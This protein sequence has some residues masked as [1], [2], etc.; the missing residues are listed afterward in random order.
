MGSNSSFS[1]VLLVGFLALAGMMLAGCASSHPTAPP[2]QPTAAVPLPDDE[3]NWWVV[4]YRIHWP[5]GESPDWAIDLLLAHAVVKPS[6]EIYSQRLPY[7]RFHRRAARDASGHQFSF[8]FYTDPPTA[9]AIYASLEANPVLGKLKAQGLITQI[10]KDDPDRPERPNI[11]DT[12][13]PKWSPTLQRHWPAY[14]MGV[15][16]LW[17]GLIDDAVADLPVESYA[18]YDPLVIYRAADKRVSQIWFK[19]GQHAFLHH[20]SAVFGYRELLIVKP[21]RF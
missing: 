16:Q 13:D 14:I 1:R 20:L 9:R 21:L 7:W 6:L 3:L 8:L 12:S 18:G 4:R 11:E 5:E 15:S 19:E 2:P 10:V 17:L